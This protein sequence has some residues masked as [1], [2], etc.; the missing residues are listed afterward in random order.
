MTNK[1]YAYFVF[2]DDSVE[3]AVGTEAI[4]CFEIRRRAAGGVPAGLEVVA[5]DLFS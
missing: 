1:M 2:V 5:Q 3:R 4:D